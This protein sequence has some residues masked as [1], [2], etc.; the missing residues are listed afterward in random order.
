MGHLTA[1]R[2]VFD[3]DETVEGESGQECGRQQSDDALAE[4]D[5][6]LSDTRLTVE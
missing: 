6:L 4:H 1:T 2:P 5:D 3:G